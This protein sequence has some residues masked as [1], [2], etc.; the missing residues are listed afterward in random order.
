LLVVMSGSDKPYKAKGSIGGLIALSSSDGGKSWGPLPDLPNGEFVHQG[1]GFTQLKWH[2]RAGVCADATGDVYYIGTPNCDSYREGQDICMY[3][4]AFTGRTWRP[5]RFAVIY[6]NGYKCPAYGRVWRLSNGRIWANWHDGFG[7][8]FAK[9]SDD[10]GFTFEPC[11]DASVDHTPRPFYDPDPGE[12]A[13]PP[14]RVIL[15]PADRVV[16]HI[17][18]PFRGQIATISM[19]GTGWQFHDGKEWREPQPSP[20]WPRIEIPADSGA[21][22]GKA[23]HYRLGTA[24]AVVVGEDQIVMVRGTGY[25]NSRRREPRAPLVAAW[26]KQGK[27]QVAQIEREETVGLPILTLSGE[28]VYCFY[29]MP[30]AEDDQ[31]HVCYRRFVDGKWSERVRLATEPFRIN[32]LAAPQISPPSYAA[33]FYDQWVNDF[34]K[35]SVVRFI[36]VP[37]R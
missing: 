26:L 2:L 32:H 11:K 8:A 30:A 23:K 35:P 22:A 21:R 7:G 25:D 3:R 1:E 31:Y 12:Q 28:A 29:V 27:W 9:H 20:K 15:F 33:L 14:N 24:S 19:S 10:D 4:L 16:G 37:N 13:D 17:L 34:K 36:R 5:D 18:V 6:Q